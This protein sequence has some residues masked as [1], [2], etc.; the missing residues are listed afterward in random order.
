M[1]TDN[2][3]TKTTAISRAP[4]QNLDQVVLVDKYDRVI[5]QA[6]KIEAHRGAGQLHR[7]ISVFLFDGGGN[8]LIQQRSEKKIIAPLKWANT[9]CGNVRPG[10]KY[11]ECAYRRL[12]EELGVGV[13][14]LKPI[15]KFQ[16]QFE[17]D[18]GFAENEIDVVFVGV[19]SGRAVPNP[20]EVKSCAW[21]LFDDF[22]HQLNGKYAPWVEIIFYHENIY[23]ILIQCQ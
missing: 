22:R 11:E 16:Y 3:S 12:Q 14:E 21:M 10:E 15:G 9:C 2:Q 7:A 19:Y 5:G 13:V 8:L 18:N 4:G 20:A 1:M 17:F 6:D 23:Q